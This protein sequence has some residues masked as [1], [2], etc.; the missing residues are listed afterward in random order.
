VVA[1]HALAEAGLSALSDPMK[2]GVVFGSAFGS[3]DAS[4][5][6]MHRVFEKGPRFASPAEFPNLVPSSPVGH[7]SI[8]L[9][10]GGPA[11]ASA[12]LA[13]SGESAI[14]QAAEL[15]A[16]GEAEVVVAG[17]IEEA[18]DIAERILAGLFARSRVELERPR[19]EGAA[20]VVL[21]EE[22][23]AAA[24][25]ARVLAR[26]VS[27]HEWRGGATSLLSP[28]PAPRDVALARV[29]L[30]RI[31]EGAEALL[32]ASAWRDVERVSVS[33]SAG[34][35]EGLGG[36]AVA[37][38]VGLLSDGKAE[39]VLVIGLSIGRGYALTL[40]SP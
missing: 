32:D 33:P 3:V 37:V 38:A 18:S 35:H 8:Y 7:I 19:A 21:E 4:A 15:V 1:L 27:I 40:A 13:T 26:V 6:F 24:R 2:V 36:I 12:D 5:A 14:A 25:G 28:I 31:H 11:L 17:A 30:A 29:V 9:G 10:V 34:Q 22:D 39:E 20:A 16:H 23:H